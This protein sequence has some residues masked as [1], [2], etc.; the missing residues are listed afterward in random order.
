MYQNRDMCIC[1]A[2]SYTCTSTAA[3]YMPIYL[4]VYMLY[5]SYAVY[6]TLYY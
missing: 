2:A 4:L 5:Q 1:T 3:Y 6:N